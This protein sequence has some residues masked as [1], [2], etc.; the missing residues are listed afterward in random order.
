M[1]LLY[2]KL[3]DSDELLE[4]QKMLEINNWNRISEYFN[5][6]GAMKLFKSL[7]PHNLQRWSM[8]I[9]NNIIKYD[10]IIK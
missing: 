10:D 8:Q 7:K 4:L 5:C 6:K 3:Q 9:H 1:D 2:L